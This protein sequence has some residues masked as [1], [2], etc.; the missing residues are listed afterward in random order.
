MARGKILLLISASSHLVRKHGFEYINL[1]D[2]E[3]KKTTM[4]TALD[5]LKRD[6]LE[7]SFIKTKHH[8]VNLK[9]TKSV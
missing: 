7:D 8:K 1:K 2:E 5:S 4:K 6:G 3:D 9:K